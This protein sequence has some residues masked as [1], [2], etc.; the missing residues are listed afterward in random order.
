M[1]SSGSEYRPV[2]DRVITA[3][4]IWFPLNTGNIYKLAEDLLA[5]Q[6]G[7]SSV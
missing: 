1:D 2:V 4:K 3:R 6:E 7:L 5:S